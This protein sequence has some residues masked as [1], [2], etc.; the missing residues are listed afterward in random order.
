MVSKISV[1]QTITRDHYVVRITEYKGM[2]TATLIT[3]TG[4]SYTGKS[5]LADG[6][7]GSAIRQYQDNDH[8]RHI[9][10]GA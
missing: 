1:I 3:K 6:A 5:T 8:R 2:Y 7:Y 4:E 10:Y 9:G